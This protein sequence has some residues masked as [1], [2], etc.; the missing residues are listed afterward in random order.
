[1]AATD[2][3]DVIKVELISHSRNSRFLILYVNKLQ[4][5]V[6]SLGSTN[7]IRIETVFGNLYTFFF[8]LILLSF[9]FTYGL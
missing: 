3:R 1:M 9:F 8:N 5:F 2:T 6:N 7:W 4:S